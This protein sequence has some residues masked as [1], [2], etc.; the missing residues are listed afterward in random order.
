[1]AQNGEQASETEIRLLGLKSMIKEVYLPVLD[2][3][4]ASEEKSEKNEIQLYMVRFCSHI[5]TSL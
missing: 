3:Q 2:K 5:Q 1:M 4:P